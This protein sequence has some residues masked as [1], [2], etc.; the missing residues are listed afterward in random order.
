MWFSSPFGEAFDSAQYPAVFPSCSTGNWKSLWIV[1]P[2]TLKAAKPVGA[3]TAHVKLSVGHKWPT[4]D[5]IVSIR[6]DLPVPPTQLTNIW[7]SVKLQA[8][9]LASCS[10]WWRKCAFTLLKTRLWS[11]LSIATLCSKDR[12]S[13]GLV[14]ISNSYIMAALASPI[15]CGSSSLL[16]LCSSLSAC[17]HWFFLILAW[18]CSLQW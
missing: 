9:L 6:N 13:A 8:H 11:V 18:A 14:F 15:S 12:V 7:S 16:I 10:F 3:A 17:H 4:N 1:I 2:P 5:L